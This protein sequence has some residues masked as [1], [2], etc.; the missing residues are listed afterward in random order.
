MRDIPS[1]KPLP[2]RPAEA[3]PPP[4]PVKPTP[5]RELAGADGR[6]SVAPEPTRQGPETQPDVAE[7]VLEVQGTRWTVRVLGRSG[8]AAERSAPLLLLGFWR[9]GEEGAHTREATVVGHLLAD[10]SAARL[11]EA[12]ARS[13]DPPQSEGRKPFFDVGSQG[14]RGSPPRRD[15]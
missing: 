1:T 6:E 8:R 15:S 13:T 9:K 4:G 14:R 11:E 3:E 5:A 10:M 12:L 2:A 7:A